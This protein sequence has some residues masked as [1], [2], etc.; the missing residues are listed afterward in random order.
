V[1]TH[2]TLVR[3]K[4]IK[5]LMPFAPQ[6]Q[7]AVTLA[8]SLCLLMGTLW[9]ACVPAQTK[10]PI[11]RIDLDQAIHLALT[12]NH[13]LKAT[14]TLVEQS[15]AQEITAALRP[16]PVFTTDSLI[17][18]IFT[19]G[20]FTSHY[21]NSNSEVD[22]GVAYTIERGHKRQA[23]ARAAHDQT[24]VQR[25]LVGDSARGLTFNV[26]QQFISVL[27]A[28]A[29]LSFALQD[30][31]SFENTVNISTEQY[32]A[33][34]ISEGDYL[35]IKLQLLQFQTDVSSARV[36]LV[37]AKA[38]LRQLLGYDAVPAHYDVTGN[39]EFVPLQLNLQDLE[40]RALQTRPDLIAAQQGVTAA[41][42][43]YQLA[44]ANG[45][46][47]LTLQT[48]YTRYAAVNNASF[49]GNIEI[50]IFDRNQGEI[51]RTHYAISQAQEVERADSDMV[52]TD[53]R[54]AYESFKTNAEVAQLYQSG[55]L[56][57]AKDSLEISR[58]AYRRGAAS[59]L[60]FLDAERSYRAI[61]LSYLQTLANYMASVEQ[62][63]EAVGTRSLP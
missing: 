53:V 36:A 55:Y 25:S 49:L 24:I 21:F 35:K 48:E 34:D 9:A 54:N 13:N 10:S 61:E 38:G 18:P 59:L 47:D 33:G 16:N 11:T 51:A 60:D 56:K 42:S 2:S 31:E 32:K 20:A 7:P 1:R 8:A 29:T 22:V 45:K 19:P 46:R 39:L 50:P 4:G 28:K 26:A 57:Q 37:Q 62:I 6:T 44:R 27:L 23:R 15:R 12:H 17:L 52:M 41:Q 30:L 14:E 58:Y 5:L 3:A 43:Q 40:V 63:K